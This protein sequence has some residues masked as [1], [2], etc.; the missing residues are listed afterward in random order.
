MLAERPPDYSTAASA[1]TQGLD[2][3]KSSTA[4]ATTRPTGL[5]IVWLQT[6]KTRPMMAKVSPI[7][8]PTPTRPNT[9]VPLPTATCCTGRLPSG[10]GLG[11]PRAVVSS[12]STKLWLIALSGNYG[13]WMPAAIRNSARSL[14]KMSIKLT[15]LFVP[16]I[17]LPR[18][19][20][21]DLSP[22]S[23]PAVNALLIVCI[24]Q[25]TAPD[26]LAVVL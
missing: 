12:A 21:N 14:W 20:M 25:S 13:Q 1:V 4:F 2:V 5:P 24:Y 19:L 6:P 26:M 15:C 8:A 18:F 16:E 23:C 9:A 3:C 17:D 11:S 10:P 7:P 22:G